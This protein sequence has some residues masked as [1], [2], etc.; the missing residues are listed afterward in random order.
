MARR[1]QTCIDP[2]LM[3]TEYI[4]HFTL[5]KYP[6]N[7]RNHPLL[8]VGNERFVNKNAPISGERLLRSHKPFIV[9]FIGR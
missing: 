8:A 5:N 9:H 1:C 7:L 2:S 4:R 6:D 3:S